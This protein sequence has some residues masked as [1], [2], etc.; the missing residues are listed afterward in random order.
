MLS[1][2]EARHALSCGEMLT[3]TTKVF[4]HFQ[5]AHTSKKAV[6]SHQQRIQTKLTA[7]SGANDFH[8]VIWQRSSIT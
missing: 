5:P 6:S 4:L 7:Y 2:A 3:K 8:F 1:V